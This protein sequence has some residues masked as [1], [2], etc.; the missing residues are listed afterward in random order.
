MRLPRVRFTI[1][2]LMV[3]V[4][5]IA[6][7]LAGAI[8]LPRLLKQRS[9]SLSVARYYRWRESNLRRAAEVIRSCPDRGDRVMTPCRRCFA[10]WMGL[11]TEFATSHAVAVRSL[12]QGADILAVGARRYERAAAAPWA[13]MPPAPPSESAARKALLNGDGPL[14]RKYFDVL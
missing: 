14:T 5:V 12:Q 10:A 11:K 9:D 13:P 4:A 7:I 3:A 2:R 8:E 1:W 6:A